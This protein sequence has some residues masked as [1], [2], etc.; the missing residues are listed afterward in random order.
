MEEDLSNDLC[1]MG[2]AD[3]NNAWS[4]YTDSLHYKINQALKDKSY[5]LS[6]S[7]FIGIAVVPKPKPFKLPFQFGTTKL[8]DY[9]KIAELG[10]GTYGE[11]NK[12]IHSQ[13]QTIVAIK[14][15]LFEVSKNQNKINFY[16]TYRTALII[17]R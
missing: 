9:D 6:A 12:Y 8:E 2:G 10:K 7:H 4:K 14:T 1:A 3:L 16:R 15:F 13:S 11:V 5:T 17:Q